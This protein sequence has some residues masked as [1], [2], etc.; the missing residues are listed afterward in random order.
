[1]R[2]S[3]SSPLAGFWLVF[4]M[5]GMVA[6]PA[7]I[8]LHTV[9][10][11]AQ[12][13][14]PYGYTV[15]LLLFILPIAIIAFWLIPQEGIQVSKKA[16]GW[17]IALLFPLGAALDFFFARYFF[18][19]QNTQATLGIKAPAL[20]AAYRSK[21]ISSTSL[22][23]SQCFCF[24]SGWMNTGSLRIPFQMT[25]RTAS[26]LLASFGFIRNRWCSRSFW[27]WLR[28]SINETTAAQ[29]FP[30]I[31]HSWCS[32]HCYRHRCFC[33]QLDPSSTGVL[34]ASRCS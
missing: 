31:S 16:F 2:K 9:R 18:Y 25:M 13:P 26:T 29:V 17:T 4:A 10:T 34:S 1:M 21:N 8:T 23:S 20:G 30:A 33:L 24:T 3:V 15:S 7:A 6:I 27:Y 14:T 12:N 11:S 32:V 22:A 5:F 19:F 28:F